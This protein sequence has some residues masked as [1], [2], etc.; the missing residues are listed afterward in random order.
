MNISVCL[1][2]LNEVGSIEI[3]VTE[4]I[5]ELKKI[6]DYEIIVVDDSSTDGTDMLITRMAKENPKIKLISRD[7]PNGLTGAIYEGILEA[8]FPYVLWMDADGSM[9]PSVIPELVAAIKDNFMIAVGSRFVEGGGYKGINFESRNLF[10]AYKVLRRSNDSIVAVILSRILNLFLRTLLGKQVR[11]YTTG[12]ILAPKSLVIN[13]GLRG[14][15]GEYC[16]RFLHQAQR[17]GFS[18]AEVGYINLPRI[19]GESKTGSNLFQYLKRGFPYAWVA[20]QERALSIYS[21][22]RSYKP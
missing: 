10:S 19:F 7:K 20:I 4:L 17:A 15:Y 13:I 6:G 18:V 3:L 12:F 16:P 21:D 1:P 9:P 2:T 5:L 11:D 14:N 22:S 8:K